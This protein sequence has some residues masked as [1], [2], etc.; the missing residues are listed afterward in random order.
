[1]PPELATI[2]IKAGTSERGQCPHCGA[3]WVRQVEY[4]ND[5]T[6]IAGNSRAVAMGH[7]SHGMTA[8]ARAGEPR[9]IT[10]TAWAP[11]CACP[12]HQPVPQTVLDPFSGAG[13][14][15]LAADRLQRDAIGIELNPAYAAIAR[16]R[17][18]G[19]AGLFSPVAA[20]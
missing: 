7:A 8:M 19:E 13:T 12:A 4:A 18:N 16:E 9:T 14:T 17:I 1:M 6:R 15:A 3:P 5:G 2:C 10:A 20:E 11:S